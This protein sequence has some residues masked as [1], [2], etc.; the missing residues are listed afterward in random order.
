MDLE[1][2]FFSDLYFSFMYVI[3]L[4]ILGK[5]N[6]GKSTCVYTIN[7]TSKYILLFFIHHVYIFVRVRTRFSS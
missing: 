3:Y 4:D 2:F 6:T 1:Y 5:A 7:H